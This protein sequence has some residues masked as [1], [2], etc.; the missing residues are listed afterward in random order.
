M[1]FSTSSNSLSKWA[2]KN[3]I[4]LVIFSV[5]HCLRKESNKEIEFVKETVLNLGHEFI[6]LTW[7]HDNTKSALQERARKARYEMMSK[8]C[9]ELGIKDLL[10]AHHYDDFL[11]N[12]FMRKSKKS[13]ALG[14]CNSYSTFYNNIQVLR[15][16]YNVKKHRI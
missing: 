1:A 6:G 5:N 4:R 11:E 16:L 13:G 2:K 3:L 7:L 12:Y 15:P 10:T 14:L 9:H 8:K